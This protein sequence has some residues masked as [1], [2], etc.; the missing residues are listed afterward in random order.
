MND[1]TFDTVRLK[2]LKEES[3]LRIKRQKIL[4]EQDAMIHK[5]RLEEVKQNLL[6]AEQKYKQFLN[7]NN[8]SC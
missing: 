8:Q 5:I 4:I 6:L 2:V 3:D 1:P 7:E